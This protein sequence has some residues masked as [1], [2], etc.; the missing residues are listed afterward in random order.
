MTSSNDFTY[1]SL[2]FKQILNKLIFSSFQDGDES[3]KSF[4]M[5]LDVPVKTGNRIT[6]PELSQL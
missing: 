1:R 2:V 5:A 6:I 4:V 3:I